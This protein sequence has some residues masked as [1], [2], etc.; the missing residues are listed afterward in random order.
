MENTAM[1][2]F[3]SLHIAAIFLFPFFLLNCSGIIPCP[4]RDACSACKDLS[5]EDMTFG[6]PI[7]ITGTEFVPSS[8][9]VVKPYCRVKAR[10]WPEIDFEIELPVSSNWNKKMLYNGG[11]GWD[12]VIFDLTAGKKRDYAS[13]GTN[14]GHNSSLAAGLADIPFIGY[15]LA[16]VGTFD[17][18]PFDMSD[19][20]NTNVPQKLDDFAHRAAYE[21]SSLAKKIINAY[22]GTGPTYSYWMGCSNGGRGA[23]MMAQRHPEVFDGYIAGAPHFTYTG[24]CM[25]G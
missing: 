25:R 13:A 23:M 14:G 7:T 9:T 11:G 16:Q 4:D 18:T 8:L 3:K 22:Y 24:T 6:K 21:G 17:G 10:I 15:A 20:A 5:F 1:R 19:P 12:G 2:F